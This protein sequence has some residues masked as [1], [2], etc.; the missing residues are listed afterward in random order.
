M[1]VMSIQGQCSGSIAKAK[2]YSATI[3]SRDDQFLEDNFF[4]LYLLK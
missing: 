1:V 3:R 2:A 4:D